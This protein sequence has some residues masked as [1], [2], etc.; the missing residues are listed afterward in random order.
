MPKNKT[1]H[2]KYLY[3]HFKNLKQPK[4]I[5]RIRDRLL[6]TV[7]R[8]TVKQ[9]CLS[10]FLAPPSNQSNPPTTHVTERKQSAIDSMKMG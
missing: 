5:L 2:K 9:A 10:T 4:Q 1:Q 3:T 8:V 6:T 7:Q